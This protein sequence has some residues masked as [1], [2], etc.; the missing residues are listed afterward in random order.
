MV[1]LALQQTSLCWPT[2]FSFACLGSV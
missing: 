2:G 1:H